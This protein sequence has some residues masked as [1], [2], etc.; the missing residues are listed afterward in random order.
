L[1]SVYSPFTTRFKDYILRPLGPN[2]ALKLHLVPLGPTATTGPDVAVIKVDNSIIWNEERSTEL[3]FMVEPE[4]YNPFIMSRYQMEQL[5]LYESWCAFGH[6][7]YTKNLI[8]VLEELV[9][10]IYGPSA[11]ILNRIL[12]LFSVDQ[13]EIKSRDARRSTL[14]STHLPYHSGPEGRSLYC[15]NLNCRAPPG[16]LLQPDLSRR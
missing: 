2:T 8:C 3:R 6:H 12:G 9:R 10:R 4:E 1:V 13:T 7:E 16:R 15:L 14:T 5:R 11:T